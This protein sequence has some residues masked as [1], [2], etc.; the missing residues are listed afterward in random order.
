MPTFLPEASFT[1][2]VTASWRRA[3]GHGHLPRLG[4]GPGPPPHPCLAPESLII[5]WIPTGYTGLG[6]GAECSLS[7]REGS[8]QAVDYLENVR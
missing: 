1:L 7:G 6:F 4:K 3:P 5:I 2:R 8:K